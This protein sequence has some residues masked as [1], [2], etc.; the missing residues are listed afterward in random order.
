MM[1]STLLNAEMTEDGG[2]G[3]FTNGIDGGGT[4]G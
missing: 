4:I 3:K 1:F 2:V